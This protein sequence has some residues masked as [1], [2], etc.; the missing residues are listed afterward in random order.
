MKRVCRA[1][2]LS[3]LV[4]T[5]AAAQ[6][7]PLVLTLDQSIGLARERGPLGVMAR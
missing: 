2:F 3:L 1:F 7:L 4:G 5:A 6:Q